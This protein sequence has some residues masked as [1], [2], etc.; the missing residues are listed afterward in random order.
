ME[1]GNKEFK[2]AAMK[3]CNL[4]QKD[5]GNKVISGIKSVNKRNTLPWEWNSI[6]EL[7]KNSGTEVLSEWDEELIRMY[8]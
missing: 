1:Y 4:L 5:L 8:W 2:I 7:N 3:K 6:K